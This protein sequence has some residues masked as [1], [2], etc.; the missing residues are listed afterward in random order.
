[1]LPETRPPGTRPAPGR[2]SPWRAIVGFGVVSL[3]ADVVYEGARSITGP[4]LEH[5]GASAVL[6]GVVTGV[7]EAAALMLRLV[8][9]RAADRSS[10]YWPLTIAGYALTAVSVPALAITPFIGGAGLAVA[11]ALILAERV[12]KA[13]RSP[14]KSTLL[15]HVA[16]GVGLGRAF[17][18]HKALDQV[19]AFAGPLIVGGLVAATGVIWP[20]MAVLALPGAAAIVILAWMRRRVGEPAEHPK[21]GLPTANPSQRQAVREDSERPNLPRAFWLFAASSGAATAGL[22]TFGVISFHLARENVVPLAAI[23]V[24][25]AAGM[26][27]EAVA[28]LATGFG[29]DCVRGKVLYLLPAFIAAVP[30]LAFANHVALTLIGVLVWGAANGIQDSTVKALVADLVPAGRRATAYGVFAA[31]QGAGAIAG[32]TLAGALYARSV[33]LLG[34]IIAAIEAVALGLYI[35]TLRFSSEIPGSRRESVR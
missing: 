19:G 18:V 25:Y 8:F 10:R 21:A 9:G 14:A 6:V 35:A 26:A 3:A 32:G 28:A 29:Y 33:P 13:V 22:V 11:C 15:A 5:L 17:G 24:I 34:W 16:T 7:G 30:W 2:L 1:M 31:V 27:I 23:P 4:L 20:G 12:G